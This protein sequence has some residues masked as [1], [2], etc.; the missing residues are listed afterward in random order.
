MDGLSREAN[1]CIQENYS[2]F[3][4]I[5]Q[6]VICHQSSSLQKYSSIWFL[7]QFPSLF[8]HPTLSQFVK[9]SASSKDIFVS[10]D[11]YPQ[12]QVQIKMHKELML[13]IMLVF[14]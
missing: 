11:I 13:G 4:F 6:S 10:L 5:I 12:R 9:A 2:V 3:L 1:E 14:S 7:T 8:F